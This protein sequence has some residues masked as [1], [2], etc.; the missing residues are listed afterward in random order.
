[1][2]FSAPNLNIYILCLQFH[3]T[4]LTP[5]ARSR[6]TDSGSSPE[7]H[8]VPVSDSL[9]CPFPAR[10]QDSRPWEGAYSS[11]FPWFFQRTLFAVGPVF[12]L[13]TCYVAASERDTL[14]RATC[15]ILK[16]GHISRF[17]VFF[18][19]SL[20]LVTAFSRLPKPLIS[21]P[22]LYAG[23][24]CFQWEHLL[25]ATPPSDPPALTHLRLHS[26]RVRLP[27][28]EICS[29][30]REAQ[31]L[32]TFPHTLQRCSMLHASYQTPDFLYW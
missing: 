14:N 21:I 27:S 10:R 9:C 11:T 4:R 13:S 25:A 3:F 8:R 6:W 26:K 16:D 24:L 7:T 18:F 19:P 22:G 1:M 17:N 23:S 2:I 31:Q 30:G 29:V 15:L 12:S 28:R 5:S 20:K 32:P